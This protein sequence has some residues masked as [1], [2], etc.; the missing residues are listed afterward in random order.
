MNLR[1]KF[2]FISILILSM[3]FLFSKNAFADVFSAGGGQSCNDVCAFHGGT[4]LTV[5]TNA[6][7]DDRNYCN[8]GNNGGD[9][10]LQINTANCGYT[11]QNE[12][13]AGTCYGGN[14]ICIKNIVPD[15][16]NCNCNV[17]PPFNPCTATTTASSTLFCIGNAVISGGNTIILQFFLKYWPYIII[18]SFIMAFYIAIMRLKLFGVGYKEKKEPE[19]M[20]EKHWKKRHYKHKTHYR[21]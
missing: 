18:L 5:G 19:I 21:L 20:R 9:C 7:A 10:Q 11:G 15:W 16:T 17:P 13:W 14:T 8:V 2:L 12:S 3:F 4:C 6:T 1:G